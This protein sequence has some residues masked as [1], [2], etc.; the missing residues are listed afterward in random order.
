MNFL[1]NV[2]CFL[3]DVLMVL[4]TLSLDTNL[5]PKEILKKIEELL[6]LFIFLVGVGGKVQSL[7][8]YKKWGGTILY[9]IIII[10]I[11]IITIQK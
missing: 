5:S 11:I 1:N 6:L 2:E 10:V 7:K 8:M 4:R 3:L 9:E